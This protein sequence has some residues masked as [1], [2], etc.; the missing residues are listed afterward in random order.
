M[1][2]SKSTKKR[3]KN[4]RIK[5]R[6][7]QKKG[8]GRKKRFELTN[9][10]TRGLDDAV[11]ENKFNNTFNNKPKAKEA[12]PESG[13]E[14]EKK[15]VAA[16]EEK[17]KEKLAE[18]ER[19]AKEAKDK[20]RVAERKEA[21][22]KARLEEAARLASVAERKAKDAEKQRVADI[23]N[24]YAIKERAK[25]AKAAT[26][27]QKIAR[28][29]A[30]KAKAAALANK[31]AE[32]KNKEIFEKLIEDPTNQLIILNDINVDFIDDG[33]KEIKKV[34]TA[35]RLIIDNIKKTSTK[36]QL[37]KLVIK[38]DGDNLDGDILKKLNGSIDE[39]YT[40]K[41][42]SFMVNVTLDVVADQN[43]IQEIK[44]KMDTKTEYTPEMAKNVA[45]SDKFIQLLK[46]AMD[47]ADAHKTLWEKIT[48]K[49]IDTSR[50]DTSR[51][52][53]LAIQQIIANSVLTNDNLMLPS[54]KGNHIK[55]PTILGIRNPTEPGDL[56]PSTDNPDLCVYLTNTVFS[57][58]R[59]G[60]EFKLLAM[61]VAINVVK[62]DRKCFGELTVNVPKGII[63]N[64]TKGY[65]SSLKKCKSMFEN[66][67]K[68]FD[69]KFEMKGNE[70][71]SFDTN[72]C[73][74]ALKAEF[75]KK[76][77]FDWGTIFKEIITNFDTNSTLDDQLDKPEYEKTLI[78]FN[79][80]T[81]DYMN[82]DN[83]FKTKYSE[84]KHLQTLQRYIDVIEM[85]KKKDNYEVEVENNKESI[86]NYINNVVNAT[87]PSIK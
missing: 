64:L 48:P 35:Y 25:A 72:N 83:D 57:E 74:V 31:A 33:Q 14:E 28:Q 51:I 3:K 43:I 59:T 80:I 49:G 41:Q 19:K 22:R 9:Y 44:N 86:N 34:V 8:G 46:A 69:P 73:I 82:I 42:I 24:Q 4:N 30:A 27:I 78:K 13:T 15:R 70:N 85:L 47:N 60:E 75:I 32:Y 55:I 20:Q 68:L 39:A 12:W 1:A 53:T 10:P 6:K 29:K 26:D 81:H 67:I 84:V 63:G 38:L 50:I 62:E 18:A 21:K 71:T 52:K 76:Y 56:F 37:D 87:L 7:A 54:A 23:R 66:I 36:D 17:E 11:S 2:T 65:L 61:Y 77:G 40:N 79:Y 5:T 58:L 16:E 45:T